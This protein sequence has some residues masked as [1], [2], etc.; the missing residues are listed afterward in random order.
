MDKQSYKNTSLW[1]GISIGVLSLLYLFVTMGKAEWTI[2]IASTA[3]VI[4]SL[5]LLIQAHILTY[6]RT[7][8]YMHIGFG[9]FVVIGT[10]L[11]AVVIFMNSLLLIQQIGNIVPTYLFNFTKSVGIIGAV[12]GI[13]LG[14]LNAIYPRLAR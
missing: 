11:F 10:T 6:I 14:L 2:Y 7:K 4:L 13:A 5:T 1:L 8:S 12:G 3:G 9:D